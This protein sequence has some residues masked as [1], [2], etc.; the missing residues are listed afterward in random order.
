MG[1]AR[2]T[3]AKN[4]DTWLKAVNQ[5]IT[6]AHDV[7]KSYP[8]VSP[9]DL[10]MSGVSRER[11]KWQTGFTRNKE[12]TTATGLSFELQLALRFA[13]PYPLSNEVYQ[14]VGMLGVPVEKLLE[15]A[16]VEECGLVEEVRW[17]IEQLCVLLMCLDGLRVAGLLPEDYEV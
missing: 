5:R 14:I 7:I 8:D 12:G 11:A 15:A 10:G 4:T 9:A 1:K 13:V 16:Y 6:D 2:A 17:A 3:G